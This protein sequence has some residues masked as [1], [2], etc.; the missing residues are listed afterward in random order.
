M[1][2]DWTTFALEAINFLILVWLL[3]RFLYRPVLDVVAQR[4][5]VVAKTLADAE[6]ARGESQRLLAEYKDRQ[7]DWEAERARLRHALDDEMQTLRSRQLA[8]LALEVESERRRDAAVRQREREVAER[9]MQT[10][11]LQQADAF[12]ARLLE[13]LAGPELDARIVDVLLADLQQLPKARRDLLA[14]ALAQAPQVDVCSAR[15]LDGVA[16]ARVEAALVGLAGR[17]LNI[18]QTQDAGLLSGLRVRAG[19]WELGADLAGE[20]AAF[21]ELTGHE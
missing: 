2:F 13:R 19:A 7:R 6:A 8:A 16:R 4:Q 10:R 11:A 5:A 14:A 1:S 12:V 9:E 21:A 3:K 20:L 17:P 18:V 15:P